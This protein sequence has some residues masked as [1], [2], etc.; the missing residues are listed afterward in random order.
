MAEINPILIEI[1]DPKKLHFSQ[2]LLPFTQ[3][4]FAESEAIFG[5]EGEWVIQL[6]VTA[7]RVQVEQRL[8][9]L[10]TRA[11][12]AVCGPTA[13][14]YEQPFP[15]P[16]LPPAPE[17]DTPSEVESTFALRMSQDR[18][19]EDTVSYRRIHVTMCQGNV[20]AAIVLS[21][22][23]FWHQPNERGESKLKVYKDGHY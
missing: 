10:V 15:Y 11:V 14:R 13:I 2:K 23:A 21:N 18:G 6:P 5:S 12:A 16:T 17:T 4:H 22:L 19:A 3:Q 20:L 1:A 9:N 7:N 8:D